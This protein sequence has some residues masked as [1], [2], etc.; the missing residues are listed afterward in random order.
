MHYDGQR[1]ESAFCDE[2]IKTCWIAKPENIAAY[3]PYPYFPPQQQSSPKQN[4]A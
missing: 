4:E 3:C 1:I 2:Q